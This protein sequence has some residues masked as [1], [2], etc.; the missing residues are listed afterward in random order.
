MD[1]DQIH[2]QVLVVLNFAAGHLQLEDSRCKHLTPSEY[3]PARTSPADDGRCTRSPWTC[4]SRLD[5]E[6]P[7]STLGCRAAADLS[8]CNFTS[9]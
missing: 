9:L 4:R 5:A 8:A 2:A 6:S 1:T 7:T 3:T